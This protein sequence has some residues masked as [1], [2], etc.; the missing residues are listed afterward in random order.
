MSEGITPACAGNT[1]RCFVDQGYLRDHPRLRGEYILVVLHTHVDPGSPPLT[2]GIL[3]TRDRTITVDGITPAYAG[4]TR[5]SGAYFRPFQDHPRLRGEYI[6]ALFGT[7]P[8][9][10]SPP[11]TRG[12]LIF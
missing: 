2:R 9:Q 10:G 7:V 6:V 3:T 12:I 11:L 4:N 5:R 8:V 1:G